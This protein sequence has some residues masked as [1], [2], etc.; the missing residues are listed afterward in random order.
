VAGYRD[1]VE[2]G[3]RLAEAVASLVTR[4]V[5]LGIPRGGVVVAAEVAAATDG[6]LA[7]LTAVKVRTPLNPEFAI[8]AVTPDGVPLLE[9]DII[10]RLRLSGQTI[11]DAVRTAVE[12]VTRRQSAFGDIPDVEG[13]DVVVVDDGVATG[14][15][16]KAAL[17]HVRRLSPAKLV[18]AV[19][20]GPPGTIESLQ[21][22]VD[23]V[24]CPLQP[25]G[26]AAVGQFYWS[27]PQVEDAEV[28]RLLA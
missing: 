24:V 3:R 22:L 14:S 6:T 19:P 13:R 28:I 9:D 8:G 26:F 7:P 17:A 1:R 20:V 5:V 11:D 12:E 23:H 21:S 4:P 16:L 10:S 25:A 2:A 15:T 18:C 27:F